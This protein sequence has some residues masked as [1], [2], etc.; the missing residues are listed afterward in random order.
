M[1]LVV[2]AVLA[3]GCRRTAPGADARAP[4]GPLPTTPDVL[5]VTIDTLRADAL[6]FAGNSRVET[7]VLDRLAREGRVFTHAHA[8]NVVTLPSHVNILTGL[9]PYQHGV[10]DN[11]GFRLAPDV[12][13]LAAMLQGKGYATA[14]FVGA[15]PLDR[16]FGLSR[17]FDVYDDRYP[18]GRG[19]L[20]FEMP[21]RPAS[22]VVEGARK[23]WLTTAG[24][25]R[26]L[27][28][29]LY[30][31]HAPYRPPSPYREKYAAEPYLGEVA[32][33]DAALAPLFE[34]VREAGARPA[35]VIVTADHGEALGDHGEETHGLF[36]YEATLHV[37]LIV[38]MPGAVAPGAVE[39]AARHVDIAPTI[40]QAAGI[41]KPAAWTGSSLLLPRDPA[42]PPG[43]YFE[44]YSAAYN[45]GWAPLRGV[46]AGG[47]KYVDLPIPELYDETA[48]PGEASNV[49]PAQEEHLRALARMLPAESAFGVTPRGELA[50]EEARKLRSLGYLS[51]SA[52]VK[53]TYGREDDPK[54]LVGA[55]RELHQA[56]DLYQR[57]D[58]AGAIAAARKLVRER[59]TMAIA[60]TNLTF[61]L[62]QSGAAA[63]ALAVY[64]EAARR[65]VVDE[66][67][68]S[69]YALALSEAG[70]APEAV[71]VLQPFLST[72]DPDTWNALGIARSDSGQA[73]EASRAFERALELD[74]ENV[75]AMENLGI[76]RLRAGDPAGAEERFRRALAIDARLPRAW[77]G[78]G[79]AQ[80]QLHREREAIDS[81][82]RAVTLDPK[83]YDALFNLGL[84]AGK[85]GMRAEARRALEQFVATAP[86]AVYGADLAKAR[87]ML[88]ALGTGS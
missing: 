63:E 43:S 13:T 45:R 6:G 83:L 49:A 19:S 41:Q 2:A 57:G 7:P 5:L 59:P 26:F 55:D 79:V 51:A 58:L 23:W 24:K 52:P 80:A 36:A 39:A 72:S 77:N 53:K 1:G 54:N 65:G 44:A 17:G 84:T 12:A 86:R 64:G 32:A 75:E 76:V 4:R 73:A 27:W 81:W 56:V 82:T 29:H 66:E 35:L 87:Q 30:D 25:P 70:R 69:H 14:A 37:P 33:V 61:L 88:Q 31:C 28:V 67:L 20:D 40:L 18:R 48:D 74:P 50:P 34:P 8:H 11:S 21:E 38:W 16:R 85:N 71:R 78:I 15:F 60:Y 68:A 3:A 46:V 10:R 42:S 9:L 22:E 47:W 62:R